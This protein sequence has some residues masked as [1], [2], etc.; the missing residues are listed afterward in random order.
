MHRWN[1]A[2]KAGNDCAVAKG[3]KDL[4]GEARRAASELPPSDAKP[5]IDEGALVLDVREQ[6]EFGK[7]RIAGARNVRVIEGEEGS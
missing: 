6:G 5:L 2:P 7:G 4:V 1:G 3:L